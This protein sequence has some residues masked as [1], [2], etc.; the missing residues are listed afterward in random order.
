L[1]EYDL[2]VGIDWATESHQ[3]CVLDRERHVLHERSIEHAGSA[4]LELLD[5]LA[6]LSADHPE[7]VA[8]GIE[9]P[10]GSLVE[11]LVERGFPVFFLNPKQLDRYRIA[12]AWRGRR[13]I[14]AMLSSWPTHC[15]P[16]SH[17]SDACASMIR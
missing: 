3:V 1:S 13:T 5:W 6:M 17:A 10:R 15:E 2:Y 12:T 16:M 8:V 14:G 7:R 4:I 9:L 11:S